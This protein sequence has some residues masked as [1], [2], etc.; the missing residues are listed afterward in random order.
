[1]TRLSQK[2]TSTEAYHRELERISKRWNESPSA[3][4]SLVVSK[5]DLPDSYRRTN[6]PV[7]RGK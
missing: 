7:N 4:A 6:N 2:F 5:E 1:M 3:L